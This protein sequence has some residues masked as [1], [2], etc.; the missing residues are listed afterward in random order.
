MSLHMQFENTNFKELYVSKFGEELDWENLDE[1]A[2]LICQE[3][4]SE[5]VSKYK[6]HST[7]TSGQTFYNKSFLEDVEPRKSCGLDPDDMDYL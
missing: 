4:K 1:F 5:I 7:S 3:Q 6:E 2:Q